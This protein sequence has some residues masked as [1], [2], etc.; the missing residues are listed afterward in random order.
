MYPTT[1]FHVFRN[2]HPHAI[3]ETLQEA[4][5]IC[6]LYYRANRSSHPLMLIQPIHK[7]AAAV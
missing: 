2:G 7:L 5:R 4:V 1:E 6:Q 3:A